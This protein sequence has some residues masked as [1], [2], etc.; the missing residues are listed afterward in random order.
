MSTGEHVLLGEAGLDE[1]LVLPVAL[2]DQ[3]GRGD[4]P[5]VAPGLE[6]PGQE[7]RLVRADGGIGAAQADEAVVRIITDVA[8]GLPPATLPGLTSDGQQRAAPWLI[9]AV[10]GQQIL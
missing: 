7:M 2:I 4:S 10:L 3:A 5:R 9:D 8:V 6:Q 1:L